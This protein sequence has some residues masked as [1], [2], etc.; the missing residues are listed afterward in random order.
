MAHMGGIEMKNRE[1]AELF[2]RIGD[3]LELQGENP[4]RV[5]SYRKASRVVG[6]LTED[7]ADLAKANKLGSLPGIGASFVEKINEYLETSKLSAYEKLAAKVPG[8]V[9]EMM[10]VPGLGPKTA[11]VLYKKAGVKSI[12]ELSKAIED[13]RLVELPG[14]GQKKLE[15]IQKG[16]RTY[17]SGQ[18]RILLG[19]ALPVAEEIIGH[20]QKLKGVRDILP[21]GSLRRRRETIG[22]V[23][24]LVSST[25]GK[26]IVQAFVSLPIVRDVLAAGETKGSARVEG[27]VQVDVRVVA[28]Q[29][30]GAAA[31]YFTGSKA[32]NIRLR[33]IAIDK[34]LKL[35]EYGVFRGNKRLAGKT[36]EEVYAALDLPWIAPELRED[37][38]EVEAAIEGTLPELIELDDIRGDLQMH[39]S[40]S[41][42]SASLE[43]LAR[44]CMDLGYE[45]LCLT[46]HS[47]SLKVARGLTPERLRDQRKEIDAL[48]KKLH[49][50]RILAGCEADILSDGKLDMPDK[51]LAQL[52]FVV[53]AIHT[54]M[55]QDEKRITQ[56]LVKAMQ[57]PHVHAIAHPT[58]RVLGQRDAYAL[59]FEEIVRVAKETGTALEINAFSDRLDLND[60]HARAARDAGVKLVINTDAHALSHLQMMRFGVATARRGWLRKSDV[61]NTLPLS[62]LLAW[63][64]KGSR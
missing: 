46:D 20:L 11:G 50:F 28:P 60:V 17:Q 9:V 36:E 45:Y 53:A 59:D 34:K 40:D 55:Q 37:R 49:G 61:L 24:I 47:Q 15:N 12:D 19:L 44:A 48:N 4:F 1:I 10:H 52:D 2:D 38:G 23:D 7:I 64:R 30:F 58:G 62:K 57:N 43:Q 51:A 27:G 18:E 21:A 29:S 25:R 54:G 3:I 8:G 39:S 14:L 41:D 16:I 56:R 33:D 13:G 63:L 31:Q 42:G 26:A 5:R 32:H 35:N 6:D 22:D